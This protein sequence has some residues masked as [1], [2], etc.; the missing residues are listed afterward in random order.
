MS[1]LP[2]AQLLRCDRLADFRVDSESDNPAQTRP[3]AAGTSQAGR[4]SSGTITEFH[5][6]VPT[7]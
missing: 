7:T 4:N 1:I 5:N 2:V 3:S 6:H